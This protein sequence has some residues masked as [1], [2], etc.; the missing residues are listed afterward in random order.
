MDIMDDPNLSRVNNVGVSSTSVE[1][2]FPSNLEICFNHSFFLS[3]LSKLSIRKTVL[4]WSTVIW[5]QPTVILIQQIVIWIQPTVM[6]IQYGDLDSVQGDLDP[7]HG[8]L[9]PVHSDLDPAHG[10]LDLGH[11]DLDVWSAM[12]YILSVESFISFY[13]LFL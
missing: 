12:T 11:G 1:N 13:H 10:D 6:W 8:D 3:L 5:I 4:S 7:V 9:D 2:I